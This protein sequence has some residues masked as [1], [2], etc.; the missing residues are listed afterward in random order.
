[1]TRVPALTFEWDDAKARANVRKHGISFEEA[2]TAFADASALLLDDDD[3]SEAEERF[4]LLGMSARARTLVVCHC[5][6][7]EGAMIRIISARRA[8]RS[9]RGRYARGETP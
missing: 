8:N 4:V 7:E 6:R 5:V 3:H 1:M 9:E 2:S